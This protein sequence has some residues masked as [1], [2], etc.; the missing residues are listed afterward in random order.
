MPSVVRRVSGVLEIRLRLIDD[1]DLGVAQAHAQERMNCNRF[2]QHD[3]T[4]RPTC[5]HACVGEGP[6]RED[7]PI[8]R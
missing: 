8:E 4:I 6:L 5:Q 7:R 3:T 1:R 2:D